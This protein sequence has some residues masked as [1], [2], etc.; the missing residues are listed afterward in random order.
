MTRKIV[1]EVL[2]AV[3]ATIDEANI[4]DNEKALAALENFG[5]DFVEPD[6]QRL[7]GWRNTVLEANVAMA[8]DGLV[9]KDLYQRVVSLLDE[10]RRQPATAAATRVTH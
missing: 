2:E 7:E 8:D 6:P 1:R 5:L 3:N 9:S 10:Y 4:R